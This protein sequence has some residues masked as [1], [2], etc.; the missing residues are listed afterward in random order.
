MNEIKGKFVIKEMSSDSPY[1]CVI[2]AAFESFGEWF[3]RCRIDGE[4]Y[5]IPVRSIEWIKPKNGKVIDIKKRIAL[6]KTNPHTISNEKGKG[7]RNS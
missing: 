5:F 7:S 2:K 6:V 1:E 3:L 4:T